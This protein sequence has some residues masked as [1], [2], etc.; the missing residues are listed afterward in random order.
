MIIRLTMIM[1]MVMIIMESGSLVQVNFYSS[2]SV[3]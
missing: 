1:L 3:S 2:M